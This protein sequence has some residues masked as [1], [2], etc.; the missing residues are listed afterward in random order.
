VLR[1]T[2]AI[3]EQIA[4]PKRMAFLLWAVEGMAVHEIAQAMQASVAATRSRIFYAQRELKAEAGKDPLLQEWLAR[5][6][7]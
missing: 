5:P 3:L 6:V 4:E 2:R 7:P 1:R